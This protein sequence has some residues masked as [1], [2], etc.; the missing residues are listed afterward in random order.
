MGVVLVAPAVAQG[1]T[2]T[3]IDAGDYHTCAITTTG[4]AACWGYNSLGQTVI[5]ANL[6]SI[7]QLSGG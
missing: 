4:S 3:A 5:P 6:G 7:T 1:A 2:H